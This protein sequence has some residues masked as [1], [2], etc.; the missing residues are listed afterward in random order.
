MPPPPFADRLIVV[1]ECRQGHL[2]AGMLTRAG[3][4]VLACPLIAILD[5][6]D[7]A[8]VVAW[9]NVL[10]RGEMDAVIFYTGE[11]VRRLMA[12]ARTAGLEA[13]VV[14]QLRRVKKIVRGNK[15][16]RELQAFGLREDLAVEPPTTDGVIAA[17]DGLHPAGLRVGVQLYG[18]DPNARLME[19]LAA[20]G[21]EPIPVAPYVYAGETEDAAVESLIRKIGAQGVDAIVFT[22]AAQWNRLRDVAEKL[23]LSELLH[24][25]LAH[26]T[27]AAIGPNAAEKLRA[28]GVRVDCVPEDGEFFM[29]P[30]VRALAEHLKPKV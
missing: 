10:A 21:A 25:G 19:A 5:A 8:K 30:T 20:R 12:T 9:L 1:P 17:L 7:Q 28:D 27:V 11:G 3:A 16:V 15:P 29:S 23:T 4:E 22:S 26:T 6:P 18:T 14:T 2:L 13:Q 24:A